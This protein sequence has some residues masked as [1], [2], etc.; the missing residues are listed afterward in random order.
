M[1]NINDI[2][3][4]PND[5]KRLICKLEEIT[6]ID[7]KYY[8]ENFVE[9]RIKSRM[10]RLN[11][12]DAKG[13]LQYILTN[14]EEIPKFLSGFT[15]NTSYFFRNIEVYEKIGQII[16]AN[17]NAIPPKFE[18]NSGMSNN[19]FFLNK[20]IY[21]HEREKTPIFLNKMSLSKKIKNKLNGDSTIY[22]W[23]CAC[24]SGEEPYSLSMFF[25]SIRDNISKFPNY[26]IIASDID[27]KALE[28]ARIGMYLEESLKEV[29]YYFKKSYFNRVNHRLGER[30]LFD[31]KIKK[32][33][34]FIKE[35]VTKGHQKK[36]KY[37]IIFCRY[38]LIY[39]DKNT[40][41][42]IL[43]ILHNKLAEGGLLVLGKT[44]TLFN[45]YKN[46][47]LVDSKNHIYIKDSK[48]LD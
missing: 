47:K 20:K 23:S 3:F 10:I 36:Y 21:Y 39:T 11:L 27:E 31:E 34:E 17:L 42:E 14:P 40:R 48:D 45:S 16:K 8:R 25:Q 18:S 19:M 7:F 32:N 41:N 2:I 44:E 15:I 5:Y 1:I 24:A 12:S 43:N 22:I 26:K 4:I 38:F 35:D 28:N 29:P 6:N 30:Y 9:K 46:L 33:I 13:Y 37:D